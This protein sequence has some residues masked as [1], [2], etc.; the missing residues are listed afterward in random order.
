MALFGA[1]HCSPCR[2]GRTRK[3][4]N[5]TIPQFSLT[6]L[7]VCFGFRRFFRETFVSVFV[8]CLGFRRCTHVSSLHFLRKVNKGS[9]HAFYCSVWRCFSSCVHHS[10]RL[11]KQCRLFLVYFCA[12]LKF[13]MSALLWDQR[14]FLELA[15]L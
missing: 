2:D 15:A 14:K 5:T 8:A 9:T 11:G 12:F 6:S 7:I 3:Y 1:P 13:I 4:L 10:A